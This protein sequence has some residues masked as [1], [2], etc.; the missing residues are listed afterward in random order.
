MPSIIRRATMHGVPSYFFSLKHFSKLMFT[1]KR[2]SNY[3]L[4]DFSKWLTDFD[5]LMTATL[6]SLTVMIIN[7][8]VW[9]VLSSVLQC[10]SWILIWFNWNEITSSDDFSFYKCQLIWPTSLLVLVNKSCYCHQYMMT[11]SASP[12]KDMWRPCS[13][14]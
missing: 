12:L 8:A 4:D 11:D 9:S 6:H 10:Y 13:S 7:Y 3:S 1:V 5:H 14:H 2:G